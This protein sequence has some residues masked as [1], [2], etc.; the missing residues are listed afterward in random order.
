MVPRD[1]SEAVVSL[2]TNSCYSARA[3][4]EIDHEE[5]YVPRLRV[6]S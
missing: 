4:Q 1:F 3:R 5:G 2:V 6:L